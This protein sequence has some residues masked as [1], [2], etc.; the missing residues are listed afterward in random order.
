VLFGTS[1]GGKVVFHAQKRFE[2]I[3]GIIGKAPVTYKSIMDPFRSVVKEKGEFEYIE[4]KPIDK[5]FFED[6]DKYD[7]G[8]TAQ[9]IDVPVL[10]FHG[11]SDT[12]VHPENSLDAAKTI[13]EIAIWKFE[14]EKHSFSD[15]AKENMNNELVHWLE[16]KITH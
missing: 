12:T 10:I 6:F 3:K 11:S 4:G 2:N 8:K 16:N 14:D 7:F 9:N 1:F 13:R 15:E 5:K